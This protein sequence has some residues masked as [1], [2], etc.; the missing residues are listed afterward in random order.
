MSHLL[1]DRR[2]KVLAGAVVAATA[3][4]QWSSLAEAAPLFNLHLEGRVQGSG[5]SFSPTV[6]ITTPLTASSVI[7]YQLVANTSPVGTIYTGTTGATAITITSLTAGFDG[8]N[9]LRADL[10]ELT[11]QDIQ[12]NIPANDVLTAG[13]WNQ[14]ADNSVG[15]AVPRGNGNSDVTGI[16]PG[17][18]P[19]ANNFSAINPEII[20]TGAMS[21]TAI[22]GSNN[23]LVNVRWSTGSGSVHVNGNG[24]ARFPSLATETGTAPLLSYAGLTLVAPEPGSL[25]LLGLA[26]LGLLARRR[27]A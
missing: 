26:G 25:S 2:F 11:S 21:V 19:G 4:S 23:S 15:V 16:R 13:Q 5:D 10:F 7:E 20:L 14:S 1:S 6:G 3:A 8:A 18:A 24:L 9:T 17:R 12:V 27:K 22:N